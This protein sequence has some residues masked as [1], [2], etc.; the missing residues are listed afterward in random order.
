MCHAA[1]KFPYS[2][3]RKIITLLL[4]EIITSLSLS[5]NPIVTMILAYADLESPD[6]GDKHVTIGSNMPQNLQE[7]AIV[8]DS[9]SCSSK[10]TRGSS[11]ESY[12]CDARAGANIFKQ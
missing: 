7:L 9:L 4:F 11:E 8:G 2:A 6:S 3:Q 12:V 5:I 1:Q 10:E